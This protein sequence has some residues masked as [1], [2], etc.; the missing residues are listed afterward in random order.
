V[1]PQLLSALIA[2]GIILLVAFPVH[3]YSHAL[4]AY[5]LGDSTARFMG[6]LTLDP[7]VHFEPFGGGMLVLSA[8]ISNGGFFFGY[9][10]PTPVNPTNLDGGR[11]G[12]ALVALAGPLS[13]L[14]MAA[15]VALPLRFVIAS[16]ELRL[17]ID[18]SEP[19]SLVFNIAV[20]FVA[21]NVF[22]FLFNLLPIPPLDGWKVLTGLVDPRTAYT[23]RQVEQY[24]ILLL[25]VVFFFAGQVLVRIARPI[26]T[27][28]LGQSPI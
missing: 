12:E 19:L 18:S 6:R 13:N 11:R 14:I 21:I 28:L 22:L 24:A 8:L 10:K 27:L 17:S 5:R 15:L 2:V 4:A 9:A 23:L 1:S 16:P 20:Y 25:I 26:L 3:E 7:R